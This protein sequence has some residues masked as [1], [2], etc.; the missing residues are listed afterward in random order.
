MD[1]NAKDGIYMDSNYQLVYPEGATHLDGIPKVVVMMVM[2]MIM[3]MMVVVRI[4]VMM[5]VIM[6][7]QG[8]ARL[9][10]PP[11]GQ[12]PTATSPHRQRSRHRLLLPLDP[13]LLWQRISHLCLPQGK[14]GLILPTGQWYAPSPVINDAW[15]CMVLH[16]V[17]LKVTSQCSITSADVSML[18]FRSSVDLRRLQAE[19]RILGTFTLFLGFL[20]VLVLIYLR[21]K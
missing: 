16:H 3:T 19:F 6:D 10:P 15:Y 9:H 4:M 11:L 2:M 12:L 1:G 18:F 5:V 7:P 17:F 8:C 13:Q 21:Q 20:C 14:S